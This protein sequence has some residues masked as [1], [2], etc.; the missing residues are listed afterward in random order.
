MQKIRSVENKFV[1]LVKQKKYFFKKLIEEVCFSSPTK[2]SFR[3]SSDVG[4]E[5][6]FLQEL[7][8]DLTNSISSLLSEYP[9]H[10]RPLVKKLLL[11]GH[12]NQLEYQYIDTYL[13]DSFQFS[14][15]N[16]KRDRRKTYL[17]RTLVHYD[18]NGF[19]LPAYTMKDA[20]H[21]L[22]R[23]MGGEDGP[24]N[25]I[26]LQRWFHEFIH[27]LTDHP[28]EQQVK[29]SLYEVQ[30]IFQKN[31]EDNEKAKQLLQKTF[32][33]M[34]HI[35]E[36]KYEALLS[37][38][39]YTN[40]VAHIYNK[41]VREKETGIIRKNHWGLLLHHAVA[42]SPEPLLEKIMDFYALRLH[43][44]VWNFDPYIKDLEHTFN[45]SIFQTKKALFFLLQQEVVDEE[46]VVALLMKYCSYFSNQ[47]TER[48]SKQQKTY[49]AMHKNKKMKQS[50]KIE[51][52]LLD[53]VYE[54]N[55]LKK[56][57]EVSSTRLPT[58]TVR[59]IYDS[60]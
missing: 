21:N 52:S 30:R 48:I 2:E 38:S 25:E 6:D 56:R 13:S 18:M 36:K 23:E 37:P 1:S 41:R 47:K 53:D 16:F 34:L 57:D 5:Y 60:L 50:K 44:L 54:Y 26:M 33:N 46:A 35:Q 17:S 24:H 29:E 51:R 32:K 15:N 42:H 7:V 8:S 4:F 3:F 55:Y 49:F 58:T 14:N 10:M 45:K 28:K 31:S 19:Q 39:E 20:H 27:L 9:D 12:K 11:E 59:K 22:K 40:L 43:K